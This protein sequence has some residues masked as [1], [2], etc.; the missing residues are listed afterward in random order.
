MKALVLILLLSLAVAHVARADDPCDGFAWNVKIERALFAREGQPAKTGL[1][2]AGAPVLAAATP[3]ALTLFPQDKVRFAVAPGKKTIPAGANGGLAKTNVAHAGRYRISLDSSAWIDL[4]VTGETVPA[5]A[6]Q[7]R[8]GCNAPHK[9]VEY[10]L[11]E[12]DVVIQLSAALP[13][14]VRLT[15]TESPPFTH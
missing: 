8:P 6:F 14:K 4:V 10:E 12:G 2:L 5:E 11:P 15:V 3:Y 13:G 7:G 1:E 9:V